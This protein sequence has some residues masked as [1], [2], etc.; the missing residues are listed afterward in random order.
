MTSA[1]PSSRRRRAL[2]ADS[3][4]LVG[5]GG[6][7]GYYDDAGN[8]VT[9]GWAD[10]EGYWFEACGE[11]DARGKW[12]GTG[13]YDVYDADGEWYETGYFDENDE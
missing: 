7:Q 10:A 8:F 5:E 13:M 12:V 4:F 11:F 1:S 9:T 6:E 2:D 3:K